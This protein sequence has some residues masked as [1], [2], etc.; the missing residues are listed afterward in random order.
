VCPLGIV[1]IA[2]LLGVGSP[3]GA[4][5]R[6]KPTNDLQSAEECARCHQD[7][8][9]YWRN[10]M[11][12]RAFDGPR[13]QEAFR[14]ARGDTGRD[15]GC[16]PCHAPAAVYMQDARF[17]KKTSWE[18]VTCDFC[19]T[20]QAIKPGAAL[21]FVVK[22]GAVK[23][24]PVKGAKPTEHD[25]AY[26]PAYTSST[27]CSPCHQFTN[28]QKYEVL[29]TYSEWQASPYPAKGTTCQ[30]CH[31][32]TATGHVVDPKVARSAASTINVHEMPGGHSIAE[33]N[34][35]LQAQVQAGRR[36]GMVEVTVN[37][38]NRGAGHKVPTGSPL[39]AIVMVVEADNSAGA[40]E[41][42]TRTFSRVVVDAAGREL[43]DE[44]AVFQRAVRTVSDTRLAPGERWSERFSFPMPS[45][46]PIR[47]V[48]RFFY[49]YTPEVA[50]RPDP[51]TPF[52]T[53]SAWL[54]AD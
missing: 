25:A 24:G 32:R 49:R 20:V 1:V 39:R 48:A 27:L 28:D 47:A 9:R 46:A 38:V 35:A 22:A 19:H 17:E 31:M 3:A 4:R 14:R 12:A 52:L 37:V 45:G 10:S 8:H 2:L 11:H 33:L 26:S 13:F 51:G 40:R 16:L 29:S 54:G 44:A 36:G 41:T 43:L 6:L 7:I 5:Q 34:R 15:P 53:V 18:G 50:G 42:A 30:A 23:T 21:P